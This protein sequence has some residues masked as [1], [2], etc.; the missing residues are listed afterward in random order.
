MM[1][2]INALST[3]HFR[4]FYGSSQDDYHTFFPNN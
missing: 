2:I 4:V 3:C 1:N